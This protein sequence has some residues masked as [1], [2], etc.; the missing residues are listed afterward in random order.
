MCILEITG[1][2]GL[3]LIVNIFTGRFFFF[4]S[5][6]HKFCCFWKNIQLEAF[7]A[8]QG[9]AKHLCLCG[10]KNVPML[11]SS[12]EFED[13]SLLTWN[14]LNVTELLV[15]WSVQPRV[16]V[17]VTVD[18][19]TDGALSGS[20]AS[21]PVGVGQR[22]G[23]MRLSP[24]MK[25][26]K[27]ACLGS[28]E[29]QQPA[30]MFSYRAYF[31]YVTPSYADIKHF[32]PSS[33]APPSSLFTWIHL[34]R[35]WFILPALT[36]V[37]LALVQRLNCM[38]LLYRDC[39]DYNYRSRF[40]VN[41]PEFRSEFLSVKL[42]KQACSGWS[43]LTIETL[44]SE[45]EGWVSVHCRGSSL[46]IMSFISSSWYLCL[47]L[48]LN[49]PS[50]TQWWHVR[51]FPLV[52]S[53][54]AAVCTCVCVRV[55]ISADVFCIIII[56][57]GC[58]WPPHPVCILFGLTRGLKLC[59]TLCLHPFYMQHILLSPSVNLKHSV[60]TDAEPLHIWAVNLNVTRAFHTAPSA[61]IFG[62]VL[63]M[64]CWI[65]QISGPFWQ[66]FVGLMLRNM[67]FVPSKHFF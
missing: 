52:K 51:Y 9:A 63:L 25:R 22:D 16:C 37:Y 28:N 57:S 30:Y 34:S 33:T 11:F 45:N 3:Q 56:H 32:L 36:T 31:V 60:W 35:F 48:V 38:F 26:E 39:F 49:V 4:G 12:N 1:E 20:A 8:F 24:V 10:R 23:G 15:C 40:E 59:A 42:C 44:W 7:S 6:A 21:R 5:P 58:K 19:I 41:K 46:Y 14:R 55:Y 13:H 53:T 54:A 47:D 2:F 64:T 62:V 67:S 17:W 43:P 27:G 18:H 61:H 66:K 50:L 65:S 29:F